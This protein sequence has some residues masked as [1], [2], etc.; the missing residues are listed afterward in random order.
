M[1]T[2]IP[3]S[4]ASNSLDSG[5]LL[6]PGMLFTICFAVFLVLGFCCHYSRVQC[7]MKGWVHRLCLLGMPGGIV[8]LRLCTY[9]CTNFSSETL[10]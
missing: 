10:G 6:M 3:R 2:A 8:D 7:L 5:M 1:L 9:V 4:I